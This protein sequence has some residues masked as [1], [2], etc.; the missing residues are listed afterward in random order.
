MTQ[1]FEPPGEVAGIQEVVEMYSQ[2]LMIFVMIAFD[3]CFLEST[4][5]TLDL[6][7]GPGMIG[8]RLGMLLCKA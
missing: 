8:V 2:L 5:H 3:G 1:G 6:A 4:V 7:I